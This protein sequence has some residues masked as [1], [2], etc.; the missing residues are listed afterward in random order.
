[1]TFV[2]DS[3]TADPFNVSISIYQQ[4]ICRMLST[5]QANLIDIQDN[6]SAIYT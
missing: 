6:Q 1:M 3:R 2:A 5:I 4:L